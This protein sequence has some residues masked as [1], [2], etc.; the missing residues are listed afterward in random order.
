MG[1]STTIKVDSR[2]LSKGFDESQNGFQFDNLR[3]IDAN[4]NQRFDKDED[5][6]IKATSDGKAI[7]L[8]LDSPDVKNFEKKY[9]IDLHSNRKF[10][11][12]PLKHYA[13][14]LDD[15]RQHANAGDIKSTELEIRRAH[16][17]AN[18]ANIKW[19]TELEREII[20]KARELSSVSKESAPTLDKYIRY[21]HLIFFSL[22][23]AKSGNHSDTSHLLSLGFTRAQEWNLQWDSDLEQKILKLAYQQGAV[24]AFQKAEIAASNGY[25][26]ESYYLAKAALW[27]AK[28]AAGID[29]RDQVDPAL[30]DPKRAA[31][32]GHKAYQKGIE[33]RLEIARQ[34]GA[35]GDKE[36]YANAMSSA[37]QLAKEAKAN[38]DLEFKIEPPELKKFPSDFLTNF[39]EIGSVPSAQDRVLFR[40]ML[41]EARSLANVGNIAG[42]D[43]ILEKAEHFAI[44]NGIPF[45]DSEAIFIKDQA[46]KNNDQFFQDLERAVSTGWEWSLP[47]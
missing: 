20:T 29:N 28:I 21:A 17:L 34:A 14:R 23:A 2:D 19:D 3:I 43:V 11:L 42:A 8:D 5:K 25:G 26:T 44:R 9:K 45:W 4:H 1:G 46:K 35:E 27:N 22:M 30:Y 7:A 32:L 10:N 18:S 15:A 38:F 24:L 39:G 33:K 31:A 37:R 12:F 36:V 40:D 13:L 6:I 41:E 47:F 16:T